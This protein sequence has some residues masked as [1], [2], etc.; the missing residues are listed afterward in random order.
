[1]LRKKMHGTVG[2]VA[3]DKR[4]N[5]AAG[6]ST[7]GTNNSLPGRI[8]DSWMIGAGCYANNETCAVSGTR[9]GEYLIRGVVAHTIAMMKESGMRI[10][11]ACDYVL[12]ERHE[13]R[14]GEIGVICIDTRGNRGNIGVSFDTTI[15]KRAWISSDSPL[16]VKILK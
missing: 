2:A 3:L 10:Q 15:M 7:G 11:E 8:G 9:E 4:G 13:N 6:T 12:H 1:M 14:R 5:L 16:T